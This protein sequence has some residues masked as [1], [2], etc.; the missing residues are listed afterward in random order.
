MSFPNYPDKHKLTSLLTADELVAY[1]ARL[2]RMPKIKPEG[3]L[4]CLERGLPHRMRWRIPV[5]RAGAMNA[6][7]YAV[8]KSKGRVAVLTSFGGGSPMVM[9][10]AEELAVMGTK[11]MVLMTWGGTLQNDI[12][13]GDI[14]VCNRAIRD[15]GAS[16][17]YLP[18]AKYVDADSSLVN[19]LANAIHKRG[20]SCSVGTTWT[21]D[22]PYRETREEVMQYQA[23]GV[24]T[25]EMESAGLFTIGQVRNVQTA[26]VVIGMDSLASLRWQT[27][28]R[29]DGIMGSLEIV[30]AAAIDVLGQP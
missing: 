25:V 19:E 21:T 16:H 22:A 20:A 29:L 17:H 11:K 9:E 3:V 5:T 10:L 2:G 26:S 30:Y 8:K 4:F 23:E 6:D 12:Q 27:P 13:P 28:E 15:E 18:A 1:R 24:K 14:I 7:V